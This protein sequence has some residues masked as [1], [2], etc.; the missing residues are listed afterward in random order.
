MALW[1]QLSAFGTDKGRY[2]IA[3][4]KQALGRT[5]T[6][7]DIFINIIDNYIATITA[8]SKV[9]EEVSRNETPP[10]PENS[11]KPNN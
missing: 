1:K 9:I 11:D 8:A 4:L 5:P 2:M 10:V 7:S 3:Q 6:L